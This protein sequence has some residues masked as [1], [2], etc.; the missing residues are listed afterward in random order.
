MGKTIVYV[1][2]C[3]TCKFW[4]PEEEF[5]KNKRNANGLSNYCK[6]C[7][8]KSAKSSKRK[9][10]RKVFSEEERKKARIRYYEKLGEIY[11]N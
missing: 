6:D 7:I 8:K 9:G 1:K 10:I 3:R 2:C 5:M 4:K 11:S